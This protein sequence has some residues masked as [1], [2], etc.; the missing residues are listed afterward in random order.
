MFPFHLAPLKVFLCL[1]CVDPEFLNCLRNIRVQLSSCHSLKTFSRLVF[2][3]ILN[4]EGEIVKD[5]VGT[6]KWLTE[7]LTIA[8]EL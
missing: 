2:D 3:I 7:M 5:L 4:K 8:F 6:E 1:F